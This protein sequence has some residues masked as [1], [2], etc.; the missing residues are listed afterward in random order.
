[1]VNT[2]NQQVKLQ[3]LILFGIITALQKITVPQNNII[4]YFQIEGETKTFYRLL[5]KTKTAWTTAER[6][7]VL[8]RITQIIANI[9]I[10]YRVF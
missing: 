5:P 2:T 10:L 9:T 4:R 6:F 1:M 8:S 7:F 3:V